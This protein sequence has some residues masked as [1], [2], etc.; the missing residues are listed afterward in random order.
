VVVRSPHQKIDKEN[1]SIFVKKHL[2]M[3]YKRSDLWR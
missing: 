3:A 1:I 2:T